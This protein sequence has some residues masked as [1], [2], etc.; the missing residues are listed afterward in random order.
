MYIYVYLS[1]Y[2]YIYHAC[3]YAYILPDVASF[4]LCICVYSYRAHPAR[5]RG[6]ADG[7]GALESYQAAGGACIL[8]HIN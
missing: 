6:D 4:V 7:W 2:T 8:N 1:I 5:Q 3:L